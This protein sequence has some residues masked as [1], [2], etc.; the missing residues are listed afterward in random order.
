MLHIGR[1]WF[2]EHL[3]RFQSEWTSPRAQ[4]KLRRFNDVQKPI[5]A[6]KLKLWPQEVHRR[7]RGNPDKMTEMTT[8]IQLLD[9]IY[10]P[11]MMSKSFFDAS[12]FIYVVLSKRY[13][14][15][16]LHYVSDLRNVIIVK[17]KY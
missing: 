7:V 10:H 9:E 3:A 4:N 8:Q 17:G 2:F 11:C 14:Y 13:L 5:L 16:F 1:N 12:F 15:F 6:Y